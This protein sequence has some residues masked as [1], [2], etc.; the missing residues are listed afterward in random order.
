[1]K[2]QQVSLEL[3]LGFCPSSNKSGIN[4]CLK[5]LPIIFN[6]FFPSLNEFVIKN[7]DLKAI[8]VSLKYILSEPIVL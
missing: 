2:Y 3:Y 4:P 1:M 8:K 6:K 5:L 7:K